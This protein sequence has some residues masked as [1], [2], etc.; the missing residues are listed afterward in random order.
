MPILLTLSNNWQ[1]FGRPNEKTPAKWNSEYK[2]YG[3]PA[4]PDVTMGETTS[5][6]D[7]MTAPPVPP[8]GLPDAGADVETTT[9]AKESKKR[10]SRDDDNAEDEEERKRKKKE[11][12]DKKEKKKAEKESKKEKKRKADSSDD[13]D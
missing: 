11:K 13:E 1:K 6:N 7:V 8:T 3:P 12:K 10:K 5:A 4:G 9:P 2:D